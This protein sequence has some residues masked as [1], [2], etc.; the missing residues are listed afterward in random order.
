MAGGIRKEG[1]GDRFMTDDLVSD[2]NIT[3]FVDV[4]LVLLIV[5]MVAAPM[6]TVTVPLD[7]PKSA[8]KAVSNEPLTV[9]FSKDGKVYLMDDEV[10]LEDLVKKVEAL[11]EGQGTDRRILIRGDTTADYG[12]FVA[13][14]SAL[15]LAG[16]TRLGLVTTSEN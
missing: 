4:M 12:R 10:R 9:S 6:M 14:M 1:S 2:I 7:L 8:S 15:S 5:F 3:P 16:Y 11:D 13:V